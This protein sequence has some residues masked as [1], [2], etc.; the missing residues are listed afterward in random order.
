[1]I[2]TIVQIVFARIIWNSQYRH[3]CAP[4]FAFYL[5]NEGGSAEYVTGPTGSTSP[6]GTLNRPVESARRPPA[7]FP[8]TRM[9]AT[10]AYTGLQRHDESKNAVLYITTNYRRPN[11]TE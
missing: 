3:P 5:H 7:L 8:G 4:H 11:P 9:P 10:A 1:M 2:R 6:T